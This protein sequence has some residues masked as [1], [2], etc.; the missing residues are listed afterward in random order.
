[1]HQHDCMLI[2]SRHSTSKRACRCPYYCLIPYV[3]VP[4]TIN[5]LLIAI[6]NLENKKDTRKI[7]FY[8]KETPSSNDNNNLSPSSSSLFDLFESDGRRWW[9]SSHLCALLLCSNYVLLSIVNASDVFL[10]RSMVTHMNA[11]AVV[12]LKSIMQVIDVHVFLR[13][14]FNSTEDC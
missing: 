7:L 10:I 9:C 8:K 12:H 1:M 11:H 5:Y 2:L 6:N 13:C 4:V 14:R 3:I